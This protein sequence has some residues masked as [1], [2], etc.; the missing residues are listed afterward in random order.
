MIATHG[1]QSYFQT[2]Q[3]ADD[4]PS[5][6]HPAMIHAALAEVGAAVENT[7]M[8]GDTSFDM[9]MGRAAGVATIGVNWGYHSIE[10]LHAAGAGRIIAT[11]AA[12]MPALEEIW[13]RG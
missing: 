12:L 7:V 10:A 8:I 13:G 11:Y 2:S 3:V 1:L 4:H 6:P 5:K 9:D